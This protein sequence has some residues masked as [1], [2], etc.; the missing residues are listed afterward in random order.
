M[1]WFYSEN[2]AQQG[3]ISDMEVTNLSRSGVLKPET[4]VWHEGM[5][6]WQP[7]SVARPDLAAVPDSVP[8]IAGVAV[9]EVSKDLM[10][11][12]IREGAYVPAFVATNPYGFNYAGFWIRLAAK[13]IDM[14]VLTVVIMVIGFVLFGG[15]F[16][17]MMDPQKMEQQDPAAMMAFMGAYFGFIAV[18]IGLQVGYN[19][20]MVWKWGG[21]L[22]KLA[23]GIK[24]VREDGASITL[25]RA[26]GRAF[27][28]MLN[29]FAC[30]F[31][32][33]MV[34]F[35]EPQKRSLQ[36]HICGTRVV[37]K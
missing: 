23:V 12:Q 29:G 5:T 19:A 2:G 26:I 1:N 27:A 36:D 9:P 15:L 34:A 37:N 35:D 24:V 21:T 16:T 17:L 6:D 30:H 25:G 4:L 7:L 18:N 13:L 20:I 10:V 22:G 11:Q 14:I 31:T 3:P 32:Y 8:N 28:D 33:L